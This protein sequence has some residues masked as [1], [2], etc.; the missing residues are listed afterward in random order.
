MIAEDKEICFGNNNSITLNV[1]EFQK[2]RDTRLGSTFKVITI[3][4]GGIF[5]T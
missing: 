5:H 3:R 4:S 1:L 2:L